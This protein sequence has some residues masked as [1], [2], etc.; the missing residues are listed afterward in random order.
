LKPGCDL[1][2]DK[3][4]E[5]KGISRGVIKTKGTVNLKLFTDTHETTHDFHVIGDSFQ[6]Q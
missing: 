5:M 3:V 1:K 2:P 6:L 4:I